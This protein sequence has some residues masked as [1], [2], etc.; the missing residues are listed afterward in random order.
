MSLG[1]QMWAYMGEVVRSAVSSGGQ[2]ALNKP[3]YRLWLYNLRALG[4]YI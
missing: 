1:A 4:A 3:Q 2:E